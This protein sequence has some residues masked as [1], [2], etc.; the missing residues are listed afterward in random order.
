MIMDIIIPPAALLALNWWTMALSGVKL[1]I[2]PWINL[3]ATSLGLW[4]PLGV[5]LVDRL[6]D[7]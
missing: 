3:G 7:D 5:S 6:R 1:W 4:H 2:L